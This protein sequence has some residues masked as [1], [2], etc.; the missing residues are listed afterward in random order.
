M[1]Q[2]ATADGATSGNASLA[3]K[4]LES[5]DNTL[6]VIKAQYSTDEQITEEV[7][8]LD[9]TLRITSS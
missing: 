5:K 6:H 9:G 1:Q 8:N 7:A 2:L 4:S 3:I